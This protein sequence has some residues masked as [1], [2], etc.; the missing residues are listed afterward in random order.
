VV[1]VTLVLFAGSVGVGIVLANRGDD[2]GGD[3][4]DGGSTEDVLPGD[5]LTDDEVHALVEELSP[6]VEEQRGLRFVD[7]VD[8]EVLDGEAY[9]ARMVADAEEDE[10]QDQ[11]D[12]ENLAR[13]LTALGLWPEDADLVEISRQFVAVSSL[14]VYEPED[15]EMVVLGGA[16]TPNLRLTLVHE[17]THA[18]DDQHFD[19][20][21]LDQLAERPDESASAYSALVEGNASRV[22]SAYEATLSDDERDEIAAEQMALLDDVDLSSIP[23][24]LFALQE[25]RYVGGEAFVDELVD[26]GG[27]AAVDEALQD[28]PTTSEQILEPDGWPEREPIVPVE[29]PEADGEPIELGTMG[30]AFLGVLVNGPLGAGGDV[31][32]WDGD[33]SVGWEDGDEFC[34]RFAIAGDVDGY[35]DA[36]SSWAERVDAEV[37]VEDDRL[38]A[39]SCS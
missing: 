4:G 33:N 18:L 36:L 38:V 35:E 24:V 29:Q 17:L 27:N 1:L 30:Q 23:P 31:P 34:V 10:D 28:P 11:E 7:D 2:D 39:E 22:E 5:V 15:D 21:R 26:D 8:V 14:G 6:F 19:L 25:W 32:E 16:D 20:S 37:D 9:R 3:A 12:L 13:A